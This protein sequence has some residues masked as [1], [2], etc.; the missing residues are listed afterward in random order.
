MARSCL[1]DFVLGDELGTGSFGTVCKAVRKADGQQYALKE[2][3]LRAMSA[4]EQEDC[5][6]ECSVLAS[7]DSPYIIRFYDSFLEK[8]SCPG[9]I[10]FRPQ[11]C[12]NPHAQPAHQHC[13]LM[14][15]QYT[16]RASCTYVWSMHKEATCMI[17]SGGSAQS[18]QRSGSGSCSFR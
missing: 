10:C 13:R 12:C 18:C 7:L 14:P 17:T 2:V 11:P 15:C 4:Q 6:K 9:T 1:D 5:I 3:D 8:V 16:C